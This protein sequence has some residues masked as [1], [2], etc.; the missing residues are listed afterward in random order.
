[1]KTLEG[2]GQQVTGKVLLTYAILN[3]HLWQDVAQTQPMEKEHGDS[4]I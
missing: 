3:N 4:D 1:M 2:L